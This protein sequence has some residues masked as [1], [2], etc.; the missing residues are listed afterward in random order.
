MSEAKNTAL[1]GAAGFGYSHDGPA[2]NPPPLSTT[3]PMIIATLILS[4]LVLVTS[5]DGSEAQNRE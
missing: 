1:V 3:N 2:T 4:A 5:W